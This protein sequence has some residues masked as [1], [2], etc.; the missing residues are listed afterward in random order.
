M[1]VVPVLL[2][3]PV[4]LE[5]FFPGLFEFDG[6]ETMVGIDP[7]V[8]ALGQV[9]LVAGAFEAGA[10]MLGQFAL[11]GLGL[12]D[13]GQSSLQVERLEGLQEQG[14]D[15]LVDVGGAK[16]LAA[17]RAELLVVGFADI[18]WLSPVTGPQRPAT[19][20]AK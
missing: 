4:S 14:G 10:P 2:Q 7:L 17:G 18:A 5:F 8:A 20:G 1:L 6:D 15:R 11:L 9:G 16:V 13:R 12:L 3:L 19:A